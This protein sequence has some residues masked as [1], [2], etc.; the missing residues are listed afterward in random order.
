MAA[1]ALT[2]AEIARVTNDK[3]V[4]ISSNS[5]EAA[6][7]AKWIANADKT[8][9]IEAGGTTDNSETNYPAS[10]AYD[11]WLHLDTRPDSASATWFLAFA[12]PT[13]MADFD[14][15]MIGGHNFGTIGGLTVTI[16]VADNNTF[17]TELHTIATFTPGT[18]NKRL[19]SYVL[20]H[21]GSDPLRYF[22][23]VSTPISRFVRLKITGTSG[24]PQVGEFWLGRRRHLP[25]KLDAPLD[26]KRQ[27]SEYI[28]HET[29]TGIVARYVTARARA[30][31]SGTTL[32]DA[33]ADISTVDS[34]W[35]ECDQGS[36]PFL[37]TEQPSTSPADTQLMIHPGELDFKLT[38]PT[39]RDLGLQMREVG[40]MVA[41]E[42]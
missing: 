21:T 42:S 31:R 5:L 13:T 40:P 3:P 17:T 4:L 35:S 14:M 9:N 30:V 39:G 22:Y 16:E 29:R 10:R 27:R 38:T 6:T 20:K 2:A 7:T 23:S 33:A 18:S 34:W 36:K 25:Y 19:V 1:T 41:V 26:D 28:D 11:R 32:I 15:A 8:A 24:T 12:M 37:F